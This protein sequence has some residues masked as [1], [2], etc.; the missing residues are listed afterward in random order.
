MYTSMYAC[1]TIVLY[2]D[3]KLYTQLHEEHINLAH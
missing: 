1:T 2:P 3:V